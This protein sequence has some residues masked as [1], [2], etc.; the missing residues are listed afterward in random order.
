MEEAGLYRRTD[1][2]TRPDDLLV[3][4]LRHGSSAALAE[5]FD[6]HV[7]ALHAFCFRRTASFEAAEDAVSTVFLEFWRGRARATIHDGSALPWLYGIGRNVCR[8]LERSR[9]RLGRALRRMPP[10]GTASADA[11]A[12]DVIGRV[13]SE[14]RMAAVLE[15]I[16]DLP[17]H[18]R[19]VFELVIWAEA[20]YESAAA[21]LDLPV[22]TVR[23]RLS[24]ARR[25]LALAAPDDS[26]APEGQHHD[27]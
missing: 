24:R 1:D 22:G 11:L 19:E 13:D 14:R 18:E 2:A 16:H 3:E 15:A 4:E 23:S 20:S 9:M 12:D 17:T 26:T 21:S 10:E 7:D 5:L 27:R 25:R 8:N 6:R